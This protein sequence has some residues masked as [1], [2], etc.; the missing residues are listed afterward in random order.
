MLNRFSC[1][2]LA[3][4]TTEYLLYGYSEGGLAD[5][6]KLDALFKSLGFTQK[7]ADSQ[8]RWAVLN[9]A[10]ILRRHEEARAKLADA[11][12]MGKSVGFCIDTIE[13]TIDEADI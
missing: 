13:E 3:G 8:V 7:K 5:I 1:I 6:N 10:L 11:M 4:V 12:S 9:T 2:A